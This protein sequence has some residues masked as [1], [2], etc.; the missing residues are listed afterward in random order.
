MRVRQLQKVPSGVFLL[1]L[2]ER[3]DPAGSVIFSRALA[4]FDTALAISSVERIPVFGRK[5]FLY[6][7]PG[8]KI[9]QLAAE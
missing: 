5:G 6:V 1:P 3:S 9:N 7:Q 2:L 8:C 4:G